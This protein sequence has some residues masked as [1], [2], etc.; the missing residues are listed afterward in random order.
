MSRGDMLACVDAGSLS[1]DASNFRQVVETKSAA[2]ARYGQDTEGLE[3]SDAACG[4][5]EDACRVADSADGRLGFNACIVTLHTAAMMARSSSGDQ[6]RQWPAGRAFCS[7]ILLA[8][9]AIFR[10][11]STTHRAIDLVSGTLEKP[12]LA[13]LAL[14]DKAE[15]FRPWM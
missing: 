10:T 5:V 3:M 9:L 7:T 15:S 1:S 6:A 8:T 12:A 13:V 11:A 14:T 2:R 4:E